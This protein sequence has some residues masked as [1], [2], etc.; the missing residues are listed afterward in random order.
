LPVPGRL[1]EALESCGRLLQIALDFTD[2][3]EALSVAHVV[4]RGQAVIL[5]AGTPLIKSRGMN[6]VRVLKMLPGSHLVA[7]D[8]KTMDTGALEAEL[9]ARSGA[10]VVSVLAVAPDETISEMV[11]AAERMDVA[12]FGDLIGYPDLLGGV[13]RLRRLGV[14]V[15]LV[16]V[17]IDVQQRLGLTASQF[18]ELLKEAVEE[19]GGPLAVAGGIKPSEAGAIADAGA[20]IVIVGGGI[21]RSPDPATVARRA[22][23]N[24]RV[25]CQWE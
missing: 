10:D 23:E 22:L 1:G 25:G 16:H 12:V 4:P 15:A 19:F 2:L 8:T 21:T 24:L 20:S 3:K 14:H 11:E 18:G 13:R 6:A 5:E 7:A 17:G 9:A